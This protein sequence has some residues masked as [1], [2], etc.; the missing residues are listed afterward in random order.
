MQAGYHVIALDNQPEEKPI[1]DGDFEFHTVDITNPD[2]TQALAA[3]VKRM[4]KDVRV[5][6]NNAGI[7]DPYMPDG[8]AERVAH[9]NRVI[10]TNLTGR[11]NGSHNITHVRQRNC[12]L[13]P[14]SD[15]H[16]RE[17]RFPLPSVQ[18]HSCC[19]NRFFHTWH[20]A[21][22][23]LFTCQAYELTS[24]NQQLRYMYGL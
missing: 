22:L 6:I 21:S 20:L 14:H 19:L 15:T 8:V 24:L 5:L 10:Q 9:W 23:L 3:E 1:Q 12:Q 13:Q 2:Q 4:H 7:A 16:C 17:T 11:I 18:V